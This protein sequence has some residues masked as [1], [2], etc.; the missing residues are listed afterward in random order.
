MSAIN[1]MKNFFKVLFV[2][3]IFGV[4]KYIY[5]KIRLFAIKIRKIVLPDFLFDK[6]V[7]P[8]SKLVEGFLY[9]TLL[10]QVIRLVSFIIKHL[11]P[12]FLFNN[13]IETKDKVLKALVYY[14]ILFSGIWII[15]PKN[16]FSRPMT[17]GERI[18]QIVIYLVVYLVLL[19]IVLASIVPF[20]L[21]L[22]NAFRTGLEI[23]QVGLS[24][25]LSSDA[26]N[27][28]VENWEILKDYAD[29]P[30]GFWNS[31]KVSLLTTVFS[32]YVSALTA[33]GFYLYK[34]KHSKFLF[35][36]I[37]VFMMVPTQLAFIGYHRFVT[38]IGLLGTHTAI[39]VPA[40]ASI[41]TVFFLRQYAS[42]VI[43][44]EI[45]ESARIDGAGETYIFH[46]IGVPLM[47]PGI[48]TMSIFTFIGSWNNY[49][50]ARVL[51]TNNPNKWTLPLQIANLKGSN[52]W[53]ENQGAL[54][55]GLAVS[56]FPIVIIFLIF[57]RWLVESIAAGAVKG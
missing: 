8:L 5:N 19:I 55:M 54:Y 56:I 17:V 1:K 44:K 10:K 7:K 13:T 16:F 2:E 43:N 27:R 25:K 36:F 22:I 41:G 18:K 4:M 35:G 38:N 49:L 32:G 45:V 30:L 39:V 52:V 6:N 33:Y 47:M 23:Q 57:S 15:V 50:G 14:L 12:S 24:F 51:L 9:Y 46:K 31:V 48:A 42:G 34:F 3:I 53:F 11:F 29:I 37:I 40:I 28:F 26:L 21:V 20:S